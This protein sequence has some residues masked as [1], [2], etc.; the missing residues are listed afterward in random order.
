MDCKYCGF[1]NIE[2]DDLCSQCGQPQSDSHLRDPKSSIERSMLKGLV[3]DLNPKQPITVNATA[4][5]SEVL[6]TLINESIGCV[7]VVNESRQLLGVF[8]ERDALMRL[9]TNANDHRDEPIENFMTPNPKGLPSNAKIAF[10]VHEMDLGHYRH[11]P[12]VDASEKA[13]G[14]ISVRDILHF[15]TSREE[16]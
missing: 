13:A 15:M 14:V 10:A 12:I 9:G 5:V 11:I 3:E 2:G 7:F 8:S 16:A 1:T 4:T 6:N